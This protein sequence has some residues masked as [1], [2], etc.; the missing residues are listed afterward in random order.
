MIASA[1]SGC[2][3]TAMW[4][5]HSGRRCVDYERE[6]WC[7]SG[8]LAVTWTGGAQF[9]FPEAN[10]CACGKPP[11]PTAAPYAAVGLRFNFMY[12]SG[13]VEEANSDPRTPLG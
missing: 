1:M 12:V 4:E 9:N 7:L 5:N 11:S 3:D 2:I 10:C 6:R 8:A 13:S